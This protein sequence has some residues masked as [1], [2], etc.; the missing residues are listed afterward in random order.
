LRKFILI[1]FFI[2][3]LC[4]PASAFPII[5]SSETTITPN[6]GISGQ[7]ITLTTKLYTNDPSNP[8]SLIPI[9]EGYIIYGG[10]T[11]PIHNGIASMTF[12]QRITD[13]VVEYTIPVNVWDLYGYYNHLTDVVLT[14]EPYIK[15]CQV[16]TS[17]NPSF[18]NQPVTITAKFEFNQ[19]N[20]PDPTFE[21]SD[22]FIDCGGYGISEIYQ[23]L[24]EDGIFTYT[25]PYYSVGKYPISV[26]PYINGRLTPGRIIT[27]EV[28]NAT[29]VPEFPTIT[30]PIAAILGLLLIVERKKK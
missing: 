17:P 24:P 13:A 25:V 1:I 15:N 21:T 27:Q 5:Q 8:G 6:P 7:N 2:I 9:D 14:I 10:T 19:P 3:L 29:N 11:V 28:V 22:V 12:K 18:V 4:F 23:R 20:P 30:L 16:S 26:E